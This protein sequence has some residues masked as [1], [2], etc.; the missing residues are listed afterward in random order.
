MNKLLMLLVLSGIGSQIT[1]MGNPL[2]PQETLK[3]QQFGMRTLDNDLLGALLEAPNNQTAGR[4]RDLLARGARRNARE[5]T[6][7]MTALHLAIFNNHGADVVRE[8]LQPARDLRELGI[9]IQALVRAPGQYSE[10][11]PL[12]IAVHRKNIPV[13]VALLAYPTEQEI[14]HIIPGV[15]AVRQKAGR[16]MSQLFAQIFMK[17]LIA[18]KL[19]E[20][21]KQLPDVDEA[22]LRAEIENNIIYALRRSGALPA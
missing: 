9:T 11:T 6:G 14:Q 13:I 21:K 17:D 22:V 20:V 3:N 18:E 5:R 19:K 7:Q 16:D 15:M 4:V 12:D 1:A 8:L 2:D 10:S